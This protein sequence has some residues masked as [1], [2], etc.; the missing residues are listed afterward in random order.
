M[1]AIPFTWS[2]FLSQGQQ[3]KQAFYANFL[4]ESKSKP[5][6]SASAS[7]LARPRQSESRAASASARRQEQVAAAVSA[8]VA[9]VLGS[10]VDPEAPLM[11][12]GLDSL[13]SVELRNSLESSLGLQ[14]PGTNT[15]MNDLL[16]FQS[17]PHCLTERCVEVQKRVRLK[18]LQEV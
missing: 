11:A 10:S 1:A 2:I 12:A 18:T 5:Q 4:L 7:Q 13:G 6:T 8:A 16:G 17:T 9:G 3:S 14:L 15:F